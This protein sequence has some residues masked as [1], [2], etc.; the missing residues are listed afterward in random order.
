MPDIDIDFSDA[1]RELVIEYVKKKYGEESVSQIITFGTL[2]SRA[3][4]K[5][6]GRVEYV[7]EAPRGPVQYEA[8]PN[9]GSNFQ[10]RPHHH[11]YASVKFF[12]SLSCRTFDAAKIVLRAALKKWL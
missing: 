2:S 7:C 9:R 6:V 10:Y 1:K 12:L 8:N 5:D 3:V 4:L 11:I